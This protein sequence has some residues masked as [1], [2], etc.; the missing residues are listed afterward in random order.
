MLYIQNSGSEC[1]EEKTEY[2]GNNLKVVKNIPSADT[3]ACACRDHAGCSVFTW[4]GLNNICYL[5][6]SDKGRKESHNQSFSGSQYCCKGKKNLQ[7]KQTNKIELLLCQNQLL[8][9]RNL[10]KLFSIKNI[11]FL[12]KKKFW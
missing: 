11:F 7:H 2:A 1:I 8:Y 3:C 4:S 9:F 12:S 5:K 10:K 6:I